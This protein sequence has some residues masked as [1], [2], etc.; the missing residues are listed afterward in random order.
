MRTVF[1]RPRNGATYFLWPLL[2]SSRPA[3]AGGGVD[4]RRGSAEPALLL[5]AG[6]PPPAEAGGGAARGRDGS[7]DRGPGSGVT[8]GSGTSLGLD[9]SSEVSRRDAVPDPADWRPN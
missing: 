4:V 3:R 1:K 6:A 2:G 8:R 9:I 5:E 7:I